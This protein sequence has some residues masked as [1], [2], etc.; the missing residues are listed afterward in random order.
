MEVEGSL[1]TVRSQV[2]A[3]AYRGGWAMIA[4]LSEAL[5]AGWNAGCRIARFSYLD[6]NRNMERLTQRF[7]TRTVGVVANFRCEAECEVAS[8]SRL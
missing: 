8:D 4:V 1:G 3:P 6:S 2:I 7:H 5:D